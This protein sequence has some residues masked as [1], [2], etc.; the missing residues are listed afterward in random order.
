MLRRQVRKLE[1]AVETQLGKVESHAKKSKRK[2]DGEGERE[3]EE[4]VVR[5][6][7]LRS[8]VI[9]GA[10]LAFTQLTADRQFAHLGLMLLGVLAQVDLAILPFAPGPG[11]EVRVEAVVPRAAS[12]AAVPAHDT[13][14]AVSRDAVFLA[15]P[16]SARPKTKTPTDDEIRETIEQE[17]AP[18]VPKSKKKKAAAGGDELDDIF[19]ALEPAAK[20]PK[21]KKR[22]KGD[23]FD[24]IFGA[25]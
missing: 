25:L 6:G 1:G 23:E 22:K 16:V 14:V 4:I 19:G 24:D 20:K 8:H 21:K 10:Y 13:G 12:P 9:P 15:E 3:G 17:P 7:H 5:A 18:H 11:P 2:G